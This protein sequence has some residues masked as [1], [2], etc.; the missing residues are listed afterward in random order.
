LFHH[1]Q[2]FQKLIHIFND[3]RASQPP[4]KPILGL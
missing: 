3:V 1:S 2:R 4:Q